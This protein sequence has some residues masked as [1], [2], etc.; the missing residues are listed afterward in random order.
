MSSIENVANIDPTDNTVYIV[1]RS[2]WHRPR[3]YIIGGLSFEWPLGTED[4]ILSGTVTLAKH[5][6]IG[7][8]IAEVQVVHRDDAT[9]EMSG[10]FPGK[11]G[12]QNMKLCRNVIRAPDPPG[13]KRLELPGIYPTAQKVVVESYQFQRSRDDSSMSWEY[14]I[15]FSLT[16]PGGSVDQ[17][18]ALLSQA[19]TVGFP[20]AFRGSSAR[21]YTVKGLRRTLRTIAFE[22][23]GDPNSWKKLFQLN[24]QTLDD[25]FSSV[26]FAVVATTELPL[27]FKIQY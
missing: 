5:L 3:F 27:G 15:T 8:D 24:E 9:V 23:Y 21:S 13:H 19:P 16:G 1:P 18:Q 22:V 2:L 17:P 20:A 11:T 14:T 26:P 4:I 7:D 6:Y 25:Y 10:T 12:A